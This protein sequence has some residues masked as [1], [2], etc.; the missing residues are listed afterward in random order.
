[1]NSTSNTAVLDDVFEP[2]AQCLTPEVARRIARATGGVAT[3]EDLGVQQARHSTLN[4]YLEKLLYL[5]TGNFAKRG[6]MNIHSHIAPL[7]GSSS[8]EYTTPVGGQAIKNIT[9]PRDNTVSCFMW[10]APTRES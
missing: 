8:R 4:S 6:A 2:F 3:Y 7:V 5:L 10:T 1:M 9:A